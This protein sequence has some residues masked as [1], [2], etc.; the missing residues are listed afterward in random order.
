MREFSEHVDG[1]DLGRRVKQRREALGMTRDELASRA[2]LAPGYLEYLEER[3]AYPTY[4]CIADL[5]DA[6]DTTVSALEGADQ[7][8]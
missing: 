5:A 3:Q 7:P 8:A 2:Q 4:E 6:L 1:T